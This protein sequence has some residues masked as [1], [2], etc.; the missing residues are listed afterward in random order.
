MQFQFQWH[1]TVCERFRT[2][3]RPPLVVRFFIAST[4]RETSESAKIKKHL[5]KFKSQ[6][7]E[8]DLIQ[9]ARNMSWY[10]AMKRNQQWVVKLQQDEEKVDSGFFP[11]KSSYKLKAYLEDQVMRCEHEMTRHGGVFVFS[12]R[13]QRLSPNTPNPLKKKNYANDH[14]QTFIDKIKSSQSLSRNHS[15]RRGFNVMVSSSGCFFFVAPTTDEIKMR[16]SS[17]VRL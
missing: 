6:I 10:G 8:I 9:V 14:K 2:K 16:V 5:R 7:H 11:R 13:S 15:H 17:S 4:V 12:F 1:Q 3:T